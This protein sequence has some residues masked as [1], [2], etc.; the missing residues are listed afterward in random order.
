MALPLWMLKDLKIKPRQ[1]V[2]L[3]FVFSL[4]TF[5]VALDILRTV[6][7]ASDNQAL[8]T[9]LEVNFA[10]IVSCLPTYRALLV[11]GQKRSTNKPSKISSYARKSLGYGRSYKGDD[12]RLPLRSEEEVGTEMRAPSNYHGKGFSVSTQPRDPYSLDPLGTHSQDVHA[13]APAHVSEPAL[14]SPYSNHV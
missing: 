4:A 3:A 9:V 8:F 2:A 13:P 10:V 14:S 12:G 11:I 1:K 5:I 7:A 6:E